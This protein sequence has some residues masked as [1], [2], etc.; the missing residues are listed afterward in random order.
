VVYSVLR[1]VKVMVVLVLVLVVVYL[2]FMFVFGTSTLFFSSQALY[3]ILYRLLHK[4]ILPSNSYLH[5]KASEL[6]N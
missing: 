3:I 5:S 2:L 6:K 1:S 4:H